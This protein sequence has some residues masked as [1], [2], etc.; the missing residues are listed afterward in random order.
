[1]KK[2]ISNKLFEKK[3][4]PLKKYFGT[5]I[6]P[7]LSVAKSNNHIYAQLIDDIKGISLCFSSTLKKS[8][9]EKKIYKATKIEAFFVGQDLANQAKLKGIHFAVF[10]KGTNRYH[11][12]IKSLAEGARKNGL[13]F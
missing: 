11:G 6:K 12:L 8:L 4:H 2:L 9:F 7:R 10:D 3:S 1:M 13:Q 5:K